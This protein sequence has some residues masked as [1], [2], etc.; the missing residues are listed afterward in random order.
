MFGLIKFLLQYGRYW[1]MKYWRLLKLVAFEIEDT[2][3]WMVLLF[4]HDNEIL[5]VL[6]FKCY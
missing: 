5:W 2:V 4:H 1:T 6:Y 3:L